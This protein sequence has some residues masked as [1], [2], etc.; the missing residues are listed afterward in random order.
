M[1]L[2]PP[3]KQRNLYTVNKDLVW[4]IEKS[5]YLDKIL[6]Y[7]PDKTIEDCRMVLQLAGEIAG[8]VVAPKMSEND[9]LS[10]KLHALAPDITKAYQILAE[11]GFM[12]LLLKNELNMPFFAAMGVYELIAQADPAVMV[13]YGLT[14]GV[15]ETLERFGSEKLKEKYITGLLNGSDVGAMLLTEDNAGSDL[16]GIITKATTTPNSIMISGTKQ[17][18]SNCD[19]S[20]HLLLARDADTFAATQGTTKGL[21]MYLVSTK[22]NPEAAKNTRIEGK[23]GLHA[24]LTGTIAYE[25]ALGYLI[26]EKGMGL[27]HMFHLM[28][29]ARLGVAAQA[30]G[31]AQAAV[32]EALNYTKE[33]MQ[34]GKRLGELP[35]M[36]NILDDISLAL[37]GMRALLYE[38]AYAVELKNH[39]GHS[40]ENLQKANEKK[41]SY[42][43]YLSKYYL[44]EECVRLCRLSLQ[45]HGGYGYTKEYLPE[46][47]LRDSLVFPIY[48]GTS[49]IQALMALGLVAKEGAKRVKNYGLSGITHTFSSHNEIRM[50]GKMELM[51]GWSLYH[52]GKKGTEYAQ[53]H[54]ERLTR[55]LANYEIAKLVLQH[56]ARP[57]HE[58]LRTLLL[59]RLLASSKK[60]YEE[61]TSL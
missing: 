16:G 49:Q 32:V 61:L 38:A 50:L 10:E 8:E 48:E 29:T 2:P 22:E 36:R 23:I 43:T 55:M 11:N 37:L 27:K 57:H 9:R 39:S 42:L 3:R 6:Q 51:L 30:L 40:D 12:G 44:A 24:S 13:R 1:A 15:A 28:H 31:V 19:A 21:S 4:M 25:N 35:A 17:F 18:I 47:F 46:Q 33:R 54:A 58:E 14:A 7:Y 53:Y 34:F 26:G 52:L 45:V 41:A 60:E 5:G 56:P 59:P 20:I